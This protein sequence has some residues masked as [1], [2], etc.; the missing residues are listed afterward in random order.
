VLALVVVDTIG[1]DVLVLEMKG[2]TRAPMRLLLKAIESRLRSAE[3]Q[4]KTRVREKSHTLR[5]RA[6]KHAACLSQAGD[7]TRHPKLRC[8]CS[9]GISF[10]SLQRWAH[11]SDPRFAKEAG[12]EQIDGCWKALAKPKEPSRT[13]MRSIEFQ[14]HYPGE[15]RGCIW[16]RC[17][18]QREQTK[19]CL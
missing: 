2:W 5:A 3:K 9:E 4:K 15:N 13:E 11:V 12:I 7:T 16:T 17:L 1:L 8:C 19:H 6:G 18:G 10:A 14:T